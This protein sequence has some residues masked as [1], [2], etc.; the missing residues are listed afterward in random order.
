MTS[1]PS[2][3]AGKGESDSKNPDPYYCIKYDYNQIQSS[4]VQ[5]TYTVHNKYSFQY[6]HYVHFITLPVEHIS[7]T[8]FLPNRN[9]DQFAGV[10]PLW[11]YFWKRPLVTSKHLCLQFFFQKG[12]PPSSCPSY[13]SGWSKL[14]KYCLKCKLRFNFKKQLLEKLEPGFFVYYLF[15]LCSYL[16]IILLLGNI[17]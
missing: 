16:I 17:M 13:P 2:Q 3:K 1:R 14:K 7:F 12:G 6:K 11:V 4:L 15:H 9:L 5:Y 10:I 8:L